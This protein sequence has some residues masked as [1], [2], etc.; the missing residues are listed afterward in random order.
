MPNADKE[1]KPKPPKPEK[2]GCLPPAGTSIPMSL[3]FRHRF[4]GTSGTWEPSGVSPSDT[5]AGTYTFAAE[6][7][8]TTISYQAGGGIAASVETHL[9]LDGFG[10]T[11]EFCILV[12]ARYPDTS[13]VTNDFLRFGLQ[14]ANVGTGYARYYVEVNWHSVQGNQFAFKRDSGAPAVTTVIANSSIGESTGVAAGGSNT[15]AGRVGFGLVKQSG[16]VYLIND[17]GRGWK[18]HT[19]STQTGV[20]TFDGAG[21]KPFVTV[22]ANG[23]VIEEIQVWSASDRKFVLSGTFDPTADPDTFDRLIKHYDLADEFDNTDPRAGSAVK[24]APLLATQASPWTN[25]TEVAGHFTGGLKYSSGTNGSFNLPAYSLIPQ[26]DFFFGMWTKMLTD[27]SGQSLWS[28]FELGNRSTYGTMIGIKRSSATQFQLQI[29]DSLGGSIGLTST[30]YDFPFGAVPALNDEV[31]FGVSVR[32]NGKVDVIVNGMLAKGSS[33]SPDY[34]FARGH[35]S[36]WMENNLQLDGFVFA[37]DK[38]SNNRNHHIEFSDPYIL[39]GSHGVGYAPPAAPA[40]TLTVDPETEPT[41]VALTWKHL[42]ALGG[43]TGSAGVYPVSDATKGKLGWMRFDKFNIGVQMELSSGGNSSLATTPGLS[44]GS[45]WFRRDD[46]IERTLDHAFSHGE[47]VSCEL[48]GVP[49]RMQSASA[50]TQAY[51]DNTDTVD[52]TILISSA[53]FL[54][55]VPDAGDNTGTLAGGT[56]VLGTT[57]KA[58]FASACADTV[59]KIKA[60]CLA[61]GY[62]IDMVSFGWWNEGNTSS[63]WR[64]GTGFADTK[65]AQYLLYKEARAAILAAWPEFPGLDIVSTTEYDTTYNQYYMTQLDA[66]GLDNAPPAIQVHQYDTFSYAFNDYL[67]RKVETDRVA[68]GI[69]APYATYNGEANWGILFAPGFHSQFPSGDATYAFPSK[70]IAA[71]WLWSTLVSCA[72][73]VAIS[74]AA[75]GV[76]RFCFTR[77]N[78]YNPLGASAGLGYFATS[79]LIHQATG[80]P[81]PTLNVY[82]IAQRLATEWPGVTGRTH[83]ATSHSGL[84]GISHLATKYADGTVV[85]GLG[86]YRW[87]KA[88][89][90]TETV[91]LGVDYAGYVVKRYIVDDQHSSR[92]DTGG[93]SVTLHE[94][95]EWATLDEDGAVDVTLRGH[96]VVLL[97][98]TEPAPDPPA[99]G[100]EHEQ[101]PI[102]GLPSRFRTGGMEDDEDRDDARGGMMSYGLSHAPTLEGGRKKL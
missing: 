12:Y 33:G 90:I 45:P 59:L 28:I 94:D 21:G 66:D 51:L 102:L 65:N 32:A 20:T 95:E 101:A 17:Y 7:P 44:S 100:G 53:G 35:D 60:Y 63:F 6:S 38:A 40:N 84:P 85:V 4:T 34:G 69:A 37:Y 97:E 26:R 58:R 9:P 81:H 24:L 43:R 25:V 2:G 15:N 13:P 99:P 71:A 22:P 56:M 86:W 96:A 91:S 41:G 73:S 3:L 72:K 83:C 39:F 88:D 14:W 93:A 11:E 52:V 64:T 8:D 75:K 5:G 18:H 87:N 27:W 36:A 68:K 1:K 98:I 92:Y 10:A 54:A 31:F 79:G 74:G 57:T 62:D 50:P 78:E 61:Q 80:T 16:N 76:E 23:W 67:V 19:A 47:G 42:G 55:S 49:R 48:G 89:T 30:T 77:F 82:D 29:Q 46:V 70:A